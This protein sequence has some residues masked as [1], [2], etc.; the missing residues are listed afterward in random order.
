MPRFD[1]MYK[2]YD[3]ANKNTSS[4][5]SHYNMVVEALN[6]SAAEQMV[7]NMN[8]ADR[9]NIIRCMYLGG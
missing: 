2:V 7:R 5:P 3:N 8:G 6:Q 4:G 9:T 1:V